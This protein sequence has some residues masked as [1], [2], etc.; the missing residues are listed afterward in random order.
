MSS[1]QNSIKPV[2][3]QV[4]SN[5][6]TSFSSQTE[7]VIGAN[8]LPKKLYL[9]ID[10]EGNDITDGEPVTRSELI[11]IIIESEVYRTLKESVAEI[12]GCSCDDCFEDQVREYAIEVAEECDYR[13]VEVLI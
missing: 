8:R 10:A 4:L 2:D 5:S 3:S 7:V 9:L 1:L 6:K 13:I 11:D 12:C